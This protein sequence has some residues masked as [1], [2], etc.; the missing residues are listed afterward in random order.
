MG[1]LLFSLP[2]IHPVEKLSRGLFRPEPRPA[3]VRAAVLNFTQEAFEFFFK[4]K[5]PETPAPPSIGT[6]CCFMR[7]VFHE[8]VG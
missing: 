7:L 3:L 1:A 6:G 8:L 4:G 5:R 2:A